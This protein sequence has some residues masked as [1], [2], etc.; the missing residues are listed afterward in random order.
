MGLDAPYV[1]HDQ[2]VRSLRGVF[3]G[4][5]HLPENGGHRLTERPHGDTNLVFH[6]H[7]E[8]L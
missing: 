5:T 2:R 7:L 4:N 1:G 6:R 3:R 8:T